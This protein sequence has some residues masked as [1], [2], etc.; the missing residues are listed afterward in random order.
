MANE[1][2]QETETN[3]YRY[4]SAAWLDAVAAGLT[5]GQRKYP[6]ETWREIPA[7]EHLARAMR[8]INMWLMGNREETH[9]IN[10]SMRLM[11]AFETDA[12][13]NDRGEWEKKLRE[14]EAGRL[15]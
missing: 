14:V 2:P 11:M 12:A 1:Y 7:K 13:A 15:L 8:H 5:A 3:E 4:I 9:I 6:G 10:A